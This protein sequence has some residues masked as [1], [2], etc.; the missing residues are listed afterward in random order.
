VSFALHQRLEADTVPLLDLGLSRLLLMKDA[1]YPWLI[2]VPMRE[3][4]REIHDLDKQDRATLVEEIAL[5][6]RT[7]QELYT[8]DK[9]NVGALGN[10]VEQLHVHVIARFKSDPAWPGPVWGKVPPQTYGPEALAR[11]LAELKDRLR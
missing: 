11:R 8:P 6:S 2:L 5:A 4:V 9:I 10:I 3:A 1:A 7:L